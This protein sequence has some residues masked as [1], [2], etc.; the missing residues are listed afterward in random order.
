LAPL[1]QAYQHELNAMAQRAQI[2]ESLVIARSH[3]DNQLPD[4]LQLLYMGK[5]LHQQQTDRKT[6]GDQGGTPCMSFCIPLEQR[7]TENM[8]YGKM[9]LTAFIAAHVDLSESMEIHSNCHGGNE[10]SLVRV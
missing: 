1:I 10:Q 2:A 5:H 9:T 6:S 3:C 8:I 4:V 7:N